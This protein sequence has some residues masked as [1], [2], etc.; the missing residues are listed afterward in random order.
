MKHHR[1]A[2]S[3]T[4]LLALSAAAVGAES[5]GEIE[6]PLIQVF[7]GVLELDDQTGQWEDISDNQ[8]DVDFSSLP[9]GG[10]ETEFAFGRDW[11]HWGINAGGSI[12]WKS[13]D[14]NFSGG[15]T[16]ETGGVL[17]VDVDNSLFLFELHLGGYVRGRLAERV[18]TYAAAG[19]LVMYGRHEVE[20]ERAE[21][22]PAG[23]TVDDVPDLKDSDSDDVNI[24]YYARA[25]VDFEIG[26]GQHIGLGLR[27]MST[28]LDF[29]KTVGK[30]DIEGPQYVFTYTAR[31]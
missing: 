19:P 25:G 27:Y 10:I 11:V 14:T 28:E 26:E 5:T 3:A 8:V 17:R 31:F 13:D 23:D 7:L 24:G 12:A 1:T 4:L 15:F 22:L 29:D 9:S 6:K 20:D 30:I 21:Q 2:L 16:E 18:T